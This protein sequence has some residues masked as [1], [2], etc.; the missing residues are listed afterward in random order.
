M[1]RCKKVDGRV[2]A[3]EASCDVKQIT[4]NTWQTPLK[5]ICGRD[6]G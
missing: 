6:I 1:T 5:P 3:E 2:Q 4:P